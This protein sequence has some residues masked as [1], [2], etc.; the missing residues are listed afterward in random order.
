MKQIINTDQDRDAFISRIKA[1]NLKRPY[2][3]EFKPK[4]MKRSIPQNKLLHM[5]IQCICNET[6]N[7]FETVKTE[8]KFMFLGSESKKGLKGYVKLPRSTTTLNTKEFMTFLDQI[9]SEMLSE[10]GIYL[11]RP[12]DQGFDQFYE[13]YG[14]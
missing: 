12:E 3:G 9:H 14:L 1:V 11:P 5:W 4:T 13:R 10:W 6:G 7:D 2:V 8:L